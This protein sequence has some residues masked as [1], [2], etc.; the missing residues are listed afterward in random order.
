MYPN[1]EHA[2]LLWENTEIIQFFS[3]EK[4]RL[5]G[6]LN[7]ALHH[8]KG[9]YRKVGWGPFIR[10]CSNRTKGNGF[11]LKDSRF[12]FITSVL[13][14]NSLLGDWWGTETVQACPKKLWIPYPWKCTRPGWKRHWET[15]FSERCFGLWQR[16]KWSLRSLPIPLILWFLLNA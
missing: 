5:M 10:A 16:A 3:L 8:L 11:K 4:W 6:D 7:T 14:K 13:G 9:T 1:G 15:L 12:R 2:S